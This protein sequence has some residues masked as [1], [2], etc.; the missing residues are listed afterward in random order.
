MG[1]NQKITALQN[2]IDFL[3]GQLKLKQEME[4]FIKTLADIPEDTVVVYSKYGMKFSSQI[5][6]AAKI[7]AEKINASH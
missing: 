5:G 3:E 1:A 2:R 6:K 7:L 4:D